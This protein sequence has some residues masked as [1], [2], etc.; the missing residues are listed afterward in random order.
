M[1]IALYIKTQIFL[2]FITEKRMQNKFYKFGNQGIIHKLCTNKIILFILTT[3]T[4]P[5][6]H[7]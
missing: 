7:K 5:Q 6:E 4:H 1:V 3:H 2:R